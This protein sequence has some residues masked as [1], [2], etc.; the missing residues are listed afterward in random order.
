MSADTLS[1]DD[2]FSPTALDEATELR[3]LSQAL[4]LAQGFKLIFVRC[5]QANQRQALIS[6][7][8]G[9]L[10]SLRIQEIQSTEPLVHLLDALRE[11]IQE[12]P[13][14]VLFV[15]GLEYSLPT[16]A[17]AHET[18]FVANL[19]ASRN[20]F[21]EVLNCPLVLWVPEYV[22]NAIM[23]GAPDFFS[24]RSG[25]YFFAAGPGETVELADNLTVGGGWM[26]LN[27][28]PAEKGERIRAIKSLLSDYEALPVERR[29][30][31]TEMRLRLRLANLLLLL[32][33]YHSARLYYE[34]LLEQARG[35]GDRA[36]EA[37]AYG[38]LGLI[39]YH[40]GEPSQAETCFQRA[41]EISREVQDR[42]NEAMS[43]RNLGNIYDALE[44]WDKAREAY[45]QSLEILR[46]IGSPAEEGIALRNLGNTFLRDSRLSEAE[47]CFERSVEIAHEIG[48][49]NGEA[50]TLLSLGVAYDGQGRLLEAENAF[51]QSLEL[52]RQLGDYS[53]EWRVLNNLS[54]LREQQGD[55]SGA[56]DFHR[57][58]VEILQETK[59]PELDAA[60]QRLA[61]LERK[62]NEHV[63]SQK[64]LA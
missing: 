59:G 30:E 52:G 14:N 44:N 5:N 58:V 55:L 54:L 45:Q 8:R 11:L 46:E 23:L 15:Y 1:Q 16:A 28:T 39:H 6:K 20:S 41:L 29:D 27:L 10:P 51:N 31:K 61:D 13:P 56:L 64:Q 9:E 22:L 21:P 35:L 19:N 18:P 33:S 36:N 49:R 26:L 7:L 50:N 32:G 42:F 37:A 17:E 62:A 53:A 4:R 60:R 57:R 47:K 34:Q 25:V 24:I 48:D 38:G 43:L 2:P 3:A 12:P 63:E 40:T